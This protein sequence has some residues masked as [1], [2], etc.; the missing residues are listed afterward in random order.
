MAFTVALKGAGTPVIDDCE[1]SATF[2]GLNADD[3]TDFYK[4]GTQCVGCEL[5]S[6][7]NNDVY[8]TGTWDFSTYTHIR[9]WLMTTVLNELN[10]DANGGIQVYMS[11]GTNTGYWY[12]SGSTT[13]PGGWWNP[14]LDTA[15]NVDTGTKPTMS[16]ITTIGFR[17]NL[18]SSAK[19]VESLWLDNITQT[20]GLKVYG[21][22]S[23][24]IVDFDDIFAAD[25]ATTLAAGVIRKIGGTFF[26]TGEIEFVG[27]ATEGDLLFQALSQ[28]VVFEDRPVASDLYGFNITDNG[29]CLLYTSPSPRD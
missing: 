19:K 10:T 17:F 21:N 22:T 5:W 13:Y 11:D 23:S 7:G 28:D 29:T 9:W 12:V 6:S 20:D 8:I 15:R 3:T 2:T 24:A 14:V 1:D 26:V 4:E 16:T 27:D 25:N 18:T